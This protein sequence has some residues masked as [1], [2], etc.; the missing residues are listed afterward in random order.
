MNITHN[1]KLVLENFQNKTSYFEIT[2]YEYIKHNISYMFAMKLPIRLWHTC[3]AEYFT[4]KPKEYNKYSL[5][6]ETDNRT[7]ARWLVYII[8]IIWIVLILACIIF[9]P[10]GICF[11]LGYVNRDLDG[12]AKMHYQKSE[13]NN[14]I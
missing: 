14:N 2:K 6:I 9:I 7:Q 12:Q 4:G 1:Y 8:L 5:D 11:I 3:S 13:F 10:Y